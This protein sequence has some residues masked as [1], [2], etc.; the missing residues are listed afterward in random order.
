M[1]RRYENAEVSDSRIPEM[2]RAISEALIVDMPIL[3]C[4]VVVSIIMITELM[5]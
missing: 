1:E 2:L 3:V 4:G 5:G